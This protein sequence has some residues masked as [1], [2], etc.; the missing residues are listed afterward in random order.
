MD[1]ARKSSLLVG[2]KTKRN[3]NSTKRGKMKTPQF[4]H[5]PTTYEGKIERAVGV[6]NDPHGFMADKMV[7][8]KSKGLTDTELLEALNIATSGELLLAAGLD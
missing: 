1:I 4:N 5:A 3:M 2:M 8:L 7:F 6:F